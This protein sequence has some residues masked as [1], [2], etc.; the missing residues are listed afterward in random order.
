LARRYRCRPCQQNRRPLLEVLGVEPGRISGSLARLLA[1]LAVV[2]PYPLAA[3]LAGLLL[4]VKVNAMGVWR[5][6]QRLGE[7][8]AR[9]SEQLSQY[10][11]DDRSEGAPTQNAPPGGGVECGCLYVGN[12]SAHSS[13]A[14][15]RR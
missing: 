15:N 3:Q 2:A 11:A 4:G 1:V 6:T 13:A 10:H 9:Y 7:A 5:A 8:A 12:A 14:A